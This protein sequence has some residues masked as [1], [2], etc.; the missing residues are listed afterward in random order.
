M[1]I[2][3]ILLFVDKRKRRILAPTPWDGQRG[4][5]A[6][7]NRLAYQ[8]E[9]P[10]QLGAGKPEEPYVKPADAACPMC[11]KAMSLHTI[12]RGGPGEKTFVHCPE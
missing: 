10:A 5:W 1:R 12:E 8:I 7:V 11:G 2:V 3:R 6:A 9:G 4:F